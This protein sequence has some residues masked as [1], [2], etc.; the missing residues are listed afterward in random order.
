MIIG[1][2]LS[3]LRNSE[4]SQFNTDTLEIIK[5][6]DPIAL[7]VQ[8]AYD[9][10]KAENDVL[11]NLMKPQKGS[12]YTAQVETADDRRDVAITGLNLV[13]GGLTYHFDVTTRNHAVTLLR[14]LT[15]YGGASLARENYQ[16]ETAGINSMLADWTN[17]PKLTAAITGLNL[18][19]WK[20]ELAQA[21]KIFN[22]LYLSRAEEASNGIP[23]NVRA[24]RNDMVKKYYKLRDLIASHH[25]IKNGAAPY[26][27]T[28]S[29]L[30]ALIDKYNQLLAARRSKSS[31]VLISPEA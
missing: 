27:T 20:A 17:K 4:F 29:Q 25:V 24:K 5:R 6:N 28:V 7:Q 23:A 22:D 21:N 18:D 9:S 3:K 19:A 15:Q 12:V 1:L 30:N 16:S 13:V 8:E 26:G 14:S 10:L 11:V 31:E 2:S